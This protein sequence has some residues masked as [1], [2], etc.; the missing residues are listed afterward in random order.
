MEG[1][2]RDCGTSVLHFELTGSYSR[3]GRREATAAKEAGLDPDGEFPGWGALLAF[4]GRHPALFG[5]VSRGGVS[6]RASQSSGCTG[7][8]A[9]RKRAGSIRQKGPASPVPLMSLWQQ[10]VS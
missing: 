4:L 8:R 2:G 10:G 9:R 5:G 6:S 3:E 7:G 1:V